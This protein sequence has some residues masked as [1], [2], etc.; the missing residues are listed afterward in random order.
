MDVSHAIRSHIEWFAHFA[1]L[2]ATALNGVRFRATF[3]FSMELAV[4]KY[5]ALVLE[6]QGY[7]VLSAG[8][9]GE[10]LSLLKNHAQ[11]VRA[12]VSD[13]IMPGMSGPEMIWS[14]TSRTVD[15]VANLPTIFATCLA[16]A[17][18]TWMAGR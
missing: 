2:C 10:A 11:V 4:R 17:S 18:G 1:L 15:G 13:V 8:T 14:S 16:A 12:V 6:Q 9:P 5:L 7:T 3:S